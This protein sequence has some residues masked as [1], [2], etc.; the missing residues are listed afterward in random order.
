[1]N[2]KQFWSEFRTFAFKG[3]LVDMAVGVVIGGAFGG[4][5]NALVKNILMP[6]VSYIMPGSGSYREW[7][8]GRVEVGIF[9]GELVNF[10]IVALAMFFIVVR[11]FGVMQRLL[12]PRA[13][14]PTTRE[15]PYCLSVIPLKAVKCS[16]CTSD[17]DG[18]SVPAGIPGR[19]S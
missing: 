2:P 9:L 13:D 16:Q 14:D 1:M 17:L 6:I 19:S 4:V 15:C 10:L 7:R 3:N 8:L 12:S 11:V 18:E 5:V